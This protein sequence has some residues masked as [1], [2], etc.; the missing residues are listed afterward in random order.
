LARLYVGNLATRLGR[1][2]PAD[3]VSLAV[4]KLLYE[5][6]E[7]LTASAEPGTEEKRAESGEPSH[8]VR[9]RVADTIVSRLATQEEGIPDLKLAYFAAAVLM[10]L[11][12]R[13]QRETAEAER[14]ASTWAA[15]QRAA[16]PF[17]AP[18]VRTLR[19]APRAMMYGTAYAAGYG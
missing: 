15:M 19:I 14:A 8:D 13:D 7:L 17:A 4:K 12:R 3:V 2:E 18:T 16:V 9:S 6:G 10:Y 11:Q 1:E 5:A